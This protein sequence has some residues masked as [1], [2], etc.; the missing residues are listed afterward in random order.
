M[1]GHQA[2]EAIDLVLKQME[3]FANE[4]STTNLPDD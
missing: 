2:P 3:H 1:P 4:W